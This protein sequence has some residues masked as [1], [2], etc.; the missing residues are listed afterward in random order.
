[1]PRSAPIASRRHPLALLCRRVAAGTSDEPLVLLDGEHVVSDAL[2]ARVPIRAVLTTTPE[3][4]VARAAEALGVAVHRGTPAVLDA[5]SPAR[6]PSGIVALAEWQPAPLDRLLDAQ[7]PLLVGLVDI[8][9]PGNVGAIVRSADAFGATGVVAI[10]QTANPGSWKA[11]RGAMGSTFRVPIACAGIRA[12]I[13]GARRRGIRVVATDAGAG[14][15]LDRAGLEPPLLVLLGNEGAGL[16]PDVIE[17]ADVR[18]HVPMRPGVNSLNV[19]VT[20]ALILYEARRHQP[21][22]VVRNSA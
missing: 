3:S 16:A 14:E 17:R 18:V 19:A 22:R 12:V 21:P 9:D 4:I 11:I 8:Q 15:P 13:D 2:A 20:A 6:T 5:A 10:G 1:M 7:A